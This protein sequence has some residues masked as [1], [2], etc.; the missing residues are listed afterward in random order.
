MMSSATF[1][2]KNKIFYTNTSEPFTFFN[3]IFLPRVGVSPLILEH[4]KAHVKQKHGID[5]MFAEVVSAFLWFNPVM[6]LFRR[7]LRLQHEYAADVYAVRKAPSLEGYLNCI[8]FHLQQNRLDGPVN[9]F[10]SKHIKQRIFMMTKQRTTFT[11]LALYALIAPVTAL[12]LFAFSSESTHKHYPPNSLSNAE[13]IIVVDAGHG[14]TDSGSTHA[15]GQNEKELMLSVAKSIQQAG[16]AKN[17][18][19]VLTRNTDDAVSLEDRVLVSKKYNADLFISLH[20]N[21]NPQDVSMSGIECLVSESNV[22]FNDSKQFA[23]KFIHQLS[24]LE[25]IHVNGVKQS[26]AYVLS[27]NSSPAVI[28]ELGYLSNQA[29]HAYIMNPANQ[30][31]LSENIISVVANELK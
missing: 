7:S 15:G 29:D 4:E 21:L 18:K 17:I 27:K 12:L 31:R 23:E 8:I 11:S 13:R 9:H 10:Y 22:R 25:G 19:V 16:A 6:I 1:V 26:K 24:G 3:L 20:V 30:Q 28:L 2:D 14:G 5:L